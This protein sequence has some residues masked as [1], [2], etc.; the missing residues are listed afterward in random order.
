MLL[1][2]WV[3]EHLDTDPEAA[4]VSV[5]DIKRFLAEHAHT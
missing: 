5:T 4:V 1:R 3:V 2:Q